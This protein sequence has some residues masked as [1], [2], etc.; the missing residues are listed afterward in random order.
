MRQT[1]AVLLRFVG[2]ILV[3]LGLVAL[4]LDLELLPQAFSLHDIIPFMPGASHSYIRIVPNEHSRWGARS[5]AWRRGVCVCCRQAHSQALTSLIASV[6]ASLKVSGLTGRSSGRQHRPC[7]R[8]FLW[9]VLVPSAPLVLRRR[10]PWALGSSIIQHTATHI[11]TW[12]KLQRKLWRGS[13]NAFNQALPSKASS[14]TNP[15]R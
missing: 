10:L 6:L 11:R 1:L 5:Y 3:L 7:L 8:H 2:A 13:W 12:I 15:L 4:S 14:Q 9:P